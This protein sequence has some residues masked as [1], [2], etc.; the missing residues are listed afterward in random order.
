MAWAEARRRLVEAL[1]LT[2]MLVPPERLDLE[3]DATMA[4]VDRGTQACHARAM[5]P[6]VSPK[7]AVLVRHLEG[8]KVGFLCAAVIG[9]HLMDSLWGCDGEVMLGAC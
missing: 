8:Y 7:A 4:S 3:I 1:R 9:S 5:A 6:L 2:L